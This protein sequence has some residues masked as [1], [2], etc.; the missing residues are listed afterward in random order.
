MDFKATIRVRS[1]I[2]Q[3]RNFL[4]SKSLSGETPL[5]LYHPDAA[6]PFSRLPFQLQGSLIKQLA[7]LPVHLLLGA[8]HSEKGIEIKLLN[9]LPASE[10]RKVVITPP[11]MPLDS[12]AV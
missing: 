12:Y 4:A 1:A 6:S 7:Q 9:L 5:I 8:G 2:Q 3:A 10:R 11:S